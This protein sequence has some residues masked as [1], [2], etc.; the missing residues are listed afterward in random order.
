MEA[1]TQHQGIVMPLDREN[2][3][4][5]AIIPASYLKMVTRTGYAEG[6]F[7]NWRYLG[8]TREPDPTFVLNMPRY[9]EASV[10]LSRTNFGCG[11]SR[12]HAPWALYEY[13]FRAI[14]AVG[15]ADIFYNN[16]FN[17]GILPVCLPE[18]VIQSLFD[19]VEATPG[20]TL[21]IDLASQR[22]VTP[23]EQV[24]SFDINP[25]RKDVLMQGLDAVAR[26][27]RFQ[28]D[29]AAFEASRKESTPWY[30]TTIASTGR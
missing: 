8:K 20:Y 7:T 23:D 1:F 25:F 28:E 3:D 16:C 13:G 26:T 6:L 10:I 9:R 4:T 29:I 17:V 12:E 5:D 11:S 14:I 19:A 15:F 18:N 27:L 24:Y 2:V 22:V 21:T 30:E